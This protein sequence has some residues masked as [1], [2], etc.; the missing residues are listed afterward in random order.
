LPRDDEHQR[1]SQVDYYADR[2]V[3]RYEEN[4]LR[5]SVLRHRMRATR[6]ICASSLAPSVPRL[7][8]DESIAE[9]I[10]EEIFPR[11]IF[12]SAWRLLL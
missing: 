2:K 11:I 1:E 7:S 6:S 9:G 5:I 10:T 4:W 12:E 3:V 8:A